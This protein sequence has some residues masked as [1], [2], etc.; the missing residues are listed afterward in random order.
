MPSLK[1]YEVLQPLSRDH[2]IGLHQAQLLRK[3]A[4]LSSQDQDVTINNFGIAWQE[5]ILPHF[6]DEELVLPGYIQKESSRAK[7]FEDHVKIAHLVSKVVNSDQPNCSDLYDLGQLLDEHIRWEEHH[8]FP[9]IEAALLP[10]SEQQLKFQTD[11]I[12]GKR[13]RQTGKYS[14]TKSLSGAYSQSPS[15]PASSRE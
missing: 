2:V 3:A 1:R 11:A 14:K 6:Q 4:Q 8:L 7:L 15:G 10:V 9:E 13:F 5:E 12:E